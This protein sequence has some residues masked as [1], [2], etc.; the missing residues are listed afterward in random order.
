MRV[1]W[2]QGDNTL[3]RTCFIK[4]KLTLSTMQ[5]LLIYKCIFLK[6]WM[7]L[8][9]RWSLYKEDIIFQSSLSQN[10]PRYFS[11]VTSAYLGRPEVNRK[12]LKTHTW[13]SI[14]R[15]I[16][17]SAESHW[18]TLDCPGTGLRWQEYR[19]QLSGAW[20]YCKGFHPCGIS[21]TDRLDASSV[22]A[23]SGATSAA[24]ATQA[25]GGAQG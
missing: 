13:V 11:V 23:L 22:L 15:L 16:K 4:S 2:F 6:L 17:L 14:S 18:P 3:W 20:E 24:A 19:A 7:C 1:R 10:T 9:R 12:E 25:E 8:L 21:S 5:C